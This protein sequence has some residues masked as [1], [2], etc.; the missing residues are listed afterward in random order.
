MKRLTN[1]PRISMLVMFFAAIIADQ[2]HAQGPQGKDFGFG[3]N[4]GE[5]LGATVKFY[6]NKE[7][8]LQAHL[9]SSYFASLRVGA[10]YLWHFDVFKSQVVKMY[11]GP[12]A[13]VGFG[14]KYRGWFYKKGKYIY[15]YERNDDEMGFGIRAIFGINIIPK[16]TPLEIFVEMGPFI[17]I[18][19]AFGSTFDAAIGV[20]FYP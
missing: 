2:A 9:G 19:P 3:L 15:W 14:N 11:A 18:T 16:R 6:V 13:A 17:G 10:D 8:A 5:P 20:R 7:N 4:L 12:G 1:I